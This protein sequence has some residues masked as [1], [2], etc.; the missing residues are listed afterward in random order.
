M[1]ESPAVAE[2]GRGR[3]VSLD[4]YRGA[5]MA[6]LIAGPLVYGVTS[7]LSGHA[8]FRRIAEQ[9]THANYEGCHL[10]DL[11]MPSFMLLVGV[12]LPYSHAARVRGV[13]PIARGSLRRSRR[14]AAF[15]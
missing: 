14:P 11:I 9:F 12:A 7:A 8:V 4:A 6:L 15:P 13:P 2:R 10:W 1:S 3:L 5:V